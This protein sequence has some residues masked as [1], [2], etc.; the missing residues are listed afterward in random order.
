MV[1]TDREPTNRRSGAWLAILL[2]AAG[3][4]LYL[5][6]QRPTDEPAAD[7]HP[8]IGRHLQFLK[9]EGLTGD[10]R[11]VSID[12]LVG[13]VTVLNYWGVWCPPCLREFPELV[14]LAK[15]FSD[16]KEFRFYPVS[17]GEGDDSNLE[18]LRAETAGFLELKKS[19]LATY[20]DLNA[21]SRRALVMELD[22][23]PHSFSYPTTIVFD[24]EGR[25]RG[26]WQG[27]SPS[28]V[29]EIGRTVEGL[30]GP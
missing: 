24:R 3:A 12:D 16:R 15:R 17:C 7:Q 9:L 29:E 23:P 6:V 8:A 20:A 2:M 10:A 21:A 27:Y 4:I 13:R 19:D 25:I 11:A 5:L 28:A 26:F 14:A 1:A 30:L 22:L 18:A